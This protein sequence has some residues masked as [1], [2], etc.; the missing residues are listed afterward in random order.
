MLGSFMTII[1]APFTGYY[2]DNECQINGKNNTAINLA[3]RKL[4]IS[5]L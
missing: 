3:D 4:V 1:H 2:N 5:L